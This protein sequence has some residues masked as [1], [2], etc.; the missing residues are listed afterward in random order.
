VRVENHAAVTFRAGLRVKIDPD[1]QAPAVLASVERALR[2][3]FS[4]RQMAFGQDVSAAQVTATAQGVGGVTAVQVARLYRSGALDP[5]AGLAAPL[6]ARAPLP[7]ERNE[8]LPG[9]LLTLDP[10]PLDLLE[11]L[12]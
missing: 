6:L 8:V 10:A 4:F 5:K 7:G 9:E 1:R 11:E 2:Q 3:A 12:A